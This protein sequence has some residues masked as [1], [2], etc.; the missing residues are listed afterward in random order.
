MSKRQLILLFLIV[1]LG[2]AIGG[3]G[4]AW[5]A[6]KGSRSTPAPFM[7]APAPPPPME[8]GAK[9]PPAPPLPPPVKMEVPPVVPPGPPPGTPP[10]NKKKK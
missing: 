4:G 3:F 1:F 6:M 7:M 10:Q 9:V 2:G 5:L 8:P